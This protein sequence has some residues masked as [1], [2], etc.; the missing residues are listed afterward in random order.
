MGAGGEFDWRFCLCGKGLYEPLDPK[1]GYEWLQVGRRL[2]TAKREM[3]GKILL[4]NDSW[5][6]YTKLAERVCGFL[7]ALLHSFIVLYA[8]GL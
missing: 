5:M 3:L 8:K 7:K 1:V 6:R 2:V 4:F